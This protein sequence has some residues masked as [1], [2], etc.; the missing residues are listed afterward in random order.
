MEGGEKPEAGDEARDA[1]ADEASTGPVGDAGEADPRR[2]PAIL[3][4]PAAVGAD[5]SLLFSSSDQ[6]SRAFNSAS[7]LDSLD[8]ISWV[9]E[10]QMGRAP[11]SDSVMA[12]R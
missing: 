10:G 3:E 5:R 4:Q 9:Q 12:G 7:S 8:R 6:L 1:V 11:A 2:R